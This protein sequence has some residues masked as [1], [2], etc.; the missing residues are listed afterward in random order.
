MIHGRM[1]EKGD[2][3][4]QSK[5]PAVMKHSGAYPLRRSNGMVMS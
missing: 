1:L 2:V 5:I 3:I 4:R